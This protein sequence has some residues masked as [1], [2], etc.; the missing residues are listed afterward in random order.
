MGEGNAWYETAGPGPAVTGLAKISAMLDRATLVLALF[1]Q[2][3]MFS[4]QILV[5]LLRYLTG[6]GFL[7]LQDAVSY[8]FAVVVALS[9]PLA[10]TRD[11]HVRVD[12]LR[13]RM[14]H[15]VNRRI[16]GLGHVLLTLPV[17]ALMA[18]HSWPLVSASWAILEGSR[19][20]GGLPG[21]FLVIGFLLVMPV[22]F[23]VH[24]LA[25]FGKPRQLGDHSTGTPG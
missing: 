19:E 4:C 9:I 16:D 1:L 24:G 2:G 12:V 11:R 22:L 23:L 8:S 21:R 17:F 15:R 7:E 13:E 14:S 3:L 5:V 10:L 6:I 18:W 25:W 20:T